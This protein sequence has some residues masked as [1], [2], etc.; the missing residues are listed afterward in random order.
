MKK[1]LIIDDDRNFI[2]TLKDSLKEKIHNKIDV[3]AFDNVKDALVFIASNDIDL[4]ILDVHLEGIHGFEFLNIIKKNPKFSSIP[5]IMM[6]ARYV[7][8]LDRIKA[9][10]M[11]ASSYFAKPVDIEKLCFEIKTY[12]EK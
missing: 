2:D 6:S 10:N 7:E 4:I 11:G 12:V 5:V 8:P 9:V 1:I 3:Y